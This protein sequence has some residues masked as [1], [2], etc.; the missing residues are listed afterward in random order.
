MFNV[1]IVER[2]GSKVVVLPAS[3]VVIQMPDGTPVSVAAL[4]GSASSVLVSHCTDSDFQENLSKLG[5]SDKV[6]VTKLKG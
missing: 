6:T 5:I 1:E 2:I 4:Y 3:Q